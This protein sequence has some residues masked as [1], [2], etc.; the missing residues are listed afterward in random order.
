L[1]ASEPSTKAGRL[2]EPGRESQEA[3][4]DAGESNVATDA[5]R[6]PRRTMVYAANRPGCG[7]CFRPT[8]A[9]AIV[10]PIPERNFKRKLSEK[11][12]TLAAPEEERS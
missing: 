1:H 5:V 6:P 11:A 7:L 8:R 4:P 12:V 2:I 3:V 9:A 10:D